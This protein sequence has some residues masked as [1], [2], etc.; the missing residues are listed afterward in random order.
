MKY[1]FFQVEFVLLL[2]P[3]LRSAN[4]KWINGSQLGQ[5]SQ[6]LPG[7]GSINYI[8][9]M[10]QKN[11]IYIYLCTHAHIYIYIYIYVHIYSIFICTHICM[12][13]YRYIFAIYTLAVYMCRIYMWWIYIYIYVLIC[14][15]SVVHTYTVRYCVLSTY[16]AC[17]RSQLGQTSQLWP[18]GHLRAINAI[19]P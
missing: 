10:Y 14:N 12:H 16:G 4:L 6:R 17:N 15:S 2:Q 7:L 8:A 19:G 1:V 13:I 3:L 11:I 5:T 9:K 18:V